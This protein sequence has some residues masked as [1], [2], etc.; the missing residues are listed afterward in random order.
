M[1][2]IKISSQTKEELDK[3]KIHH[4]EIYDDVVNRLLKQITE[5]E[6]PINENEQTTNQDET[7]KTTD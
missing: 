2:T 6:K 4:R 1:I 7:N 3:I 5:I